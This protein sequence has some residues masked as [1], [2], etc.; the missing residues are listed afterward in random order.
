MKSDLC[1]ISDV[2]QQKLFSISATWEDTSVKNEET[3][4]ILKGKVIE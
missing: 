2:S 3:D 1:F 4:R